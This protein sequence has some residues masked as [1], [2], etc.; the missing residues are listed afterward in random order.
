[1]EIARK[2]GLDHYLIRLG[3]DFF[4]DFPYHAERCIYIS[5]GMSPITRA[6]EIILNKKTREFCDIRVT[7]NSASFLARGK[8]AFRRRSIPAGYFSRDFCLLLEKCA[9]SPTERFFQKLDKGHVNGRE[10]LLF[11]L[12][13]EIRQGSWTGN[14]AL[15]L[16][17]IWI[18]APYADEDF[19]ELM[20]RSPA[21]YQTKDTKSRMAHKSTRDRIQS[22]ITDLICRP[23]PP[24]LHHYIIGNANP[25]LRTIP[26]NLS[27]EPAEWSGWQGRLLR[28]RRLPIGMLDTFYEFFEFPGKMNFIDR[29][30]R[31][32]NIYKLF[33][34]MEQYVHYRLWLSGPLR[35]FVGDILLDRQT[36]QRGYFNPSFITKAVNDHLSG[37]RCYSID[38]SRLISFELWHRLFVDNYGQ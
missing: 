12:Q 19:I 10:L 15:E 20:F 35:E 31:T 1:M 25:I 21:C 7:G 29:F 18:R 32:S 24:E 22:K 13:Q 2:C 26:I 38:F 8:S 6:H 36:L 33:L 17:Q 34:G 23:K 37:K 5:D 16:S 3:E 28:M 4:K 14:R 30:I 9:Q 27:E 11:V